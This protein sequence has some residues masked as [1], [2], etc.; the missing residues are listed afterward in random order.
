VLCQLSYSHHNL[1][2]IAIL[3]DSASQPT[4]AACHLERLRQ[5]TKHKQ[6]SHDFL[7]LALA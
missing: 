7:P 3:V 1:S 2:I 4:V 5:D 6:R